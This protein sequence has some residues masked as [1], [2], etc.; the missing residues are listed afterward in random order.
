MSI[1]LA[2]S[3]QKRLEH[4][5]NS[6]PGYSP[7]SAPKDP[8]ARRH[9]ARR[10]ERAAPAWRVRTARRDGGCGVRARWGLAAPCSMDW[11]PPP[12]PSFA[13]SVC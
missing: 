1:F 2:F 4:I 6:M 3:L 13:L 8:L 5:L 12:D 9:I 7:P 10:W 11:A